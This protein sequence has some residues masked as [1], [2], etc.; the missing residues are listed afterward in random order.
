[1]RA[2]PRTDPY[3]KCY[4]IRFLPQVEREIAGRDKGAGCGDGVNVVA[5][6]VA[7][8]PTSI[9]SDHAGYGG[10][11]P[12]ATDELPRPR[13]VQAG[14]CCGARHGNSASLAPHVEASGP[15]PPSYDA[16]AYVVAA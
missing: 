12:G 3:V 2:T 4:L 14:D 5:P 8:E 9:G 11:A 6:S 10:E 13:N 7:C 16:F 15:F 1:M